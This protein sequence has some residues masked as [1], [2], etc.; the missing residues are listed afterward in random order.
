MLREFPSF[1]AQY[2]AYAD[3]PLVLIVPPSLEE[4]AIECLRSDLSG[5]DNAVNMYKGRDIKLIVSPLL[6]TATS[7]WFLCTGLTNESPYQLWERSAPF[8]TIDT[9]QTNRQLLISVDVALGSGLGPQPDGVIG[10]DV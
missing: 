2:T 10:A 1:Q 6:D 7:D 8:Y 5:A 9:S 3:G 4:A